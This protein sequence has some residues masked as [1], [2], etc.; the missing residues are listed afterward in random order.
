MLP[1]VGVTINGDEMVYGGHVNVGGVVSEFVMANEHVDIWLALSV[2]VQP[3]NV[4]PT[5]AKLTGLLTLQ[6]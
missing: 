1:F 5:P 4:V 2:A 6:D 3:I